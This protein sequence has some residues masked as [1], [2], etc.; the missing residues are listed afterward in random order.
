ML[1]IGFAMDQLGSGETASWTAYGV[2]ANGNTVV[3]T[4]TLDG[5]STGNENA[6]VEQLLIDA[7]DYS[8]V[9]YFSKFEFQSLDNDGNAGSDEK[10]RM[11]FQ[12]VTFVDYNASIPLDF[13]YNLTDFDGDTASGTIGASL[14]DQGYGSNA[15]LLVADSNTVD[16][17]G[18]ANGTSPDP[19]LVT[20]TGNLLSNDSGVGAATI[21]DVGGQ[22]PDANGII[23][24]TTSVGHLTVYTVS[25]FFDG[26]DRA[27]GDYVY[28]L[29][30]ATTQGG[31]DPATDDMESFTYSVIDST[32]SA[33][34]PTLTIDV[35][36]D[37]PIAH[38]IVQNLSGS[39]DIVTTNLILTLDRSGSMADNF[40]GDGLFYLQI[41]RDALKTLINSADN[42]GN[43]NVMIVDFASDASSSGWLVDDVNA[44]ID[45]LDSLIASAGT[46]YDTAL[47]QVMSQYS[48]TTPP[49]ADQ[50]FSYF[51]T[52]GVPNSGHAVDNTVTYTD[53]NGVV[54]H[55]VDAWET[56]LGENNIEQSY[57]IGI[58]DV[59]SNNTTDSDGNGIR[60]GIDNLNDIAFPNNDTNTAD[61]GEEDNTALLSNP[62]DL[63]NTLLQQFSQDSI[64]GTVVGSLTSSGSSG[65]IFGADGG[66]LA[67][68]TVVA[69]SGHNYTYDAQTGVDISG[70]PAGANAQALDTDGDGVTETLRVT[71]PLGA[72]FDMNFAI[73]AYNYN[74]TVTQPLLGQQET[75]AIN[76]VDGDGDA[77]TLNLT[78]NV[79]FTAALD[80]NQDQVI[81]NIMDGS[82]IV[83]PEVA[84]LHNDVA[85]AG[86]SL[87][88]VS[89]TGA[90]L[91]SPDVLF[92]PGTIPVYL[93]SDFAQSA[94]NLL[95]DSEPNDTLATAQAISRA[96][97]TDGTVS[98]SNVD[99][100]HGRGYTH[101]AGINGNLQAGEQDWFSLNLAAGEKVW[102]DVD[103]AWA[104]TDLTVYD[105]NGGL[106]A[107]INS[108]VGN[109]WGDFVASESRT[110]YVQVSGHTA[111]EAGGYELYLSIDASSASYGPTLEGQF[112]YT[113]SDGSVADTTTVDVAG[114]TGHTLIGSDKGEILIAD[115]SGNILM[116]NAGDDS[117]VG[118]SG[119]DTL[120]G[121]A[122]N[123]LLIGGQG[124][125]SLT[126]GSGEDTF[127]WRAGDAGGNDTITDFTAGPG[128]DVLDSHELLTG[129]NATNL[130]DY[131]S[132]SSDGTDTTITVDTDGAGSAG[133][134]LMVVV[135]GVDLVGAQTD[136]AAILQ[137][138][139]DDGNLVVDQ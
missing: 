32:G 134:T 106:I 3:K 60:D 119:N 55:G 128:G 117:L 135:Q 8:D 50:T 102:I 44:A 96:Q 48:L 133:Q 41:A 92:D 31:A 105:A 33:A 21:T 51:V 93:E 139:L 86:A 130:T 58:G 26:A 57:A 116:G 64:S 68:I 47:N 59:L 109:P 36:D 69:V 28:V 7:A 80:A 94:L 6:V 11:E 90:T 27:A 83:I 30:S 89:G 19:S 95:T 76:A 46:S 56:F 125:D 112:D 81:T 61:N 97:F 113:L 107:V 71:T 4:G 66:N 23:Q 82:S 12:S 62:N 84:I 14:T 29:D 20:A 136:Q 100:Q 70:A 88:G 131:L 99:Y 67:S 54:H 5:N 72:T 24:L 101:H 98:T 104:D 124:D 121:G 52:D 114:V 38:D 87:T 79:D 77:V 15:M 65:V 103:N 120:D 111:A 129:E 110:Y 35:V 115:D 13:G 42:A 22:A 45:Y 137:Q 10:F 75:F 40:Y 49:P 78:M 16:E 74:I 127:Y 122:G 91:A 73:G 17:S 118:G 39:Q 108:S 138:L 37:V 9:A 2:D 53:V 43:V 85:N 63:A 1:S 132:V 34:S 126:G 18:L 123:D 25:G